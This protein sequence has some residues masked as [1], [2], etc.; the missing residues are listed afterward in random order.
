[1]AQK[2]IVA[3]AAVAAAVLLAG[4]SAASSSS[5]GSS[6][7]AI[8][9]TITVLTNRTDVVD[10]TFKD[11]AAKFEQ[12]YP[13]TH[14]KFEA[15]AQYETDVT[16]RLSSGNYGDVLLIPNTVSMAQLPQFFVPFGTVADLKSKYRFLGEDEYNGKAY[17]IATFGTT[18]GILYNKPVWAKAGITSNPTSPEQFIADLKLIKAKTSSIPY[19]TNY[20]AGWPLSKWEDTVGTTG[21]PNEENDLAQTDAPWAKGKYH[22]IA[23]GLLYDIVHSKL[24]EAD[25]TTTNWELSKGLLG[26]GKAS[27]MVLGSWAIA[28]MQDAAVKAGKPASDIGFMP[29]PYS[30]SGK[31]YAALQGDYKMGISTHS[32]NK[33]TALAWVN[34]VT[35]ESGYSDTVGGI[36]PL[37]GSANPANLQSFTD[38]S[39]TFIEMTPAPAGKENLLASISKEAQIDLQGNLYRQKLVDIARGAASGNKVS[40]FAQLNK[41][42]ATAKAKIAG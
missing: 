15:V 2:H 16:T 31:Q 20:A 1:M 23:D 30:V 18:L 29:F 5:G 11:Y 41:R 34:W 37:A 8:S 21:N 24:S 9:G 28:Q 22:D 17:G 40:Y 13:G 33:A 36:S 19:Y 32:S 6:K 39:V 4:C 42:W 7:S 25:P 10:T 27:S 3:T 14:V 35:N 38:A 26:T 12:K